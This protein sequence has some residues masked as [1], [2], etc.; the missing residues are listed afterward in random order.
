[1]LSKGAFKKKKTYVQLLCIVKL[2]FSKLK[3]KHIK[4]C[5]QMFGV[6]KCI[7]LQLQESKI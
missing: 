4:T 7:H 3:K 2:T 6:T 5:G 1:V